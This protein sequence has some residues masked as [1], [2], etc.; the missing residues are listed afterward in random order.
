[1]GSFDHYVNERPFFVFL[2]ES[3]ICLEEN[4]HFIQISNGCI[5]VFCPGCPKKFLKLADRK[6]S[7]A[8]ILNLFLIKLTWVSNPC[9]FYTDMIIFDWAVAIFP[10]CLNLTPKMF[11]DPCDPPWGLRV[12]NRFDCDSPWGNTSFEPKMTPKIDFA[13]DSFDTFFRVRSC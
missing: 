13:C 8:Q 10:Y 3:T 5:F 2:N 12:K 1:M 9:K 6:M 4:M 11:F 7:R